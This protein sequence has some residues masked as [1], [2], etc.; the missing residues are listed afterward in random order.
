MRA[1]TAIH[2]SLLAY[3]KQHL[4]EWANEIENTST[5]KLKQPLLGRN[6]ENSFIFVNFE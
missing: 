5:E 3:E 2:S 1:Y 4:E 6:G